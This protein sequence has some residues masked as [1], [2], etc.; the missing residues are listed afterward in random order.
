MSNINK[1]VEGLYTEYTKTQLKRMMDDQ[2]IEQVV[3]KAKEL[4]EKFPDP[5]QPPIKK[6]G[7]L[8]GLIQS[9]KTVAI[10]TLVALATDNNY[11]IFIVLTSDNIFLYEQTIER[12]QENLQGLHVVGKSNWEDEIDSIELT[13]KS[14]VSSLVLV[15][16]KNTRSLESLLNVLEKLEQRLNQP[17][18]S[19]LIIDDEADQASL[20]TQNSKRSKEPT[21]TPSSINEHITSLREKFPLSVYLQVTT[22]PQALFL[23]DTNNLYRPEFTV[24]SE[25]GKGYIGGETFFSLIDKKENLIRRIEQDDIDALL[26]S[27]GENIPQS[28][29]KLFVF[30]YSFYCKVYGQGLRRKIF[31]PMSYKP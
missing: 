29:K 31:F 19:T 28:L 16:T 8:L 9:G 3:N 15:S 10:I 25:P 5:H 22:T 17:L 30:L 13:L 21:L 12:L 26:S 6:Q 23:Q 4:L 20:D 1:V 2:G 7:L 24:L 27:R 14:N 11:K 18:P